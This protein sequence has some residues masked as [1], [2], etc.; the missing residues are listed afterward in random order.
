MLCTPGCPENVIDAAKVERRVI[1]LV[2]VEVVVVIIVNL[3]VIMVGVK[4]VVV[5]VI[6]NLCVIIRS[7][8]R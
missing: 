5:D 2:G 1:V 4:V 7:R 8:E 6:I 3:R